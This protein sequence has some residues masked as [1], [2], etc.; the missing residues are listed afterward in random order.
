MDKVLDLL[1]EI[2]DAEVRFEELEECGDLEERLE[3]AQEL[4]DVRAEHF[5]ECGRENGEE[6]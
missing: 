1:H 4:E 3:A 2:E 5:R 6:C